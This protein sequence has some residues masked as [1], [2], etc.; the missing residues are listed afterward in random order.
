MV[1]DYSGISVVSDYN[2]ISMVSDY[3][4]ISIVSDYNGIYKPTSNL[5]GKTLQDC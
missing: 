2:G 1:S 3:N 4:G 5:G